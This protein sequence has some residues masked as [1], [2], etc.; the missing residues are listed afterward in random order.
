VVVTGTQPAG[1]W[2]GALK[3]QK[4][5]LGKQDK[6][7]TPWLKTINSTPR[8]SILRLA[9][10]RSILNIRKICLC[11]EFTAYFASRW[12]RTCTEAEIAAEIA[13]LIHPTWQLL[14]TLFWCSSTLGPQW[15]T[16]FA[17]KHVR[18]GS[19]V[20]ARCPAGNRRDKAFSL[21]GFSATREISP[22]IAF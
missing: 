12:P 15:A 4:G 8:R 17:A 5:A 22:T 7:A 21:V 11:G 18:W 19:R 6:R 10:T 20:S 3:R 1:R 2:Y 16:I 9:A 14:R 13:P